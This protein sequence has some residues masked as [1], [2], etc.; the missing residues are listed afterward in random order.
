MLTSYSF[1]IVVVVFLLCLVAI[2]TAAYNEDKT[3]GL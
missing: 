3:Q 2:L 1:W